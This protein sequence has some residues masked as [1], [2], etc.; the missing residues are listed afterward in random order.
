MQK[1][2]SERI[3]ENN[4][5]IKELVDRATGGHAFGSSTGSVS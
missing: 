3:C 2:N 5:S 4:R 1:A